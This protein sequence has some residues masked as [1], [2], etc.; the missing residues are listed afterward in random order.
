[1]LPT[2]IENKFIPEPNSGCWLWFGA[3]TP[4]GYGQVLNPATR[5]VEYAHR[6]V[7]QIEKG[8]IPAGLH[9]DHL[10][11]MRCCVNPEHLEPVTTRENLLRGVGFA[12]VNARKTH[13]RHGHS[14]VGA[15]LSK[16]DNERICRVCARL[17]DL[18]HKAKKRGRS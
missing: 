14:L 4:A 6:L 7:Y 11:R 9:L 18:K 16:S 10:R 2:F 17:A 5:K 3:Q 13:C 15:R 12:A 8:V 1:M